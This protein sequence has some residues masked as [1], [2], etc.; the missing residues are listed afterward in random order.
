MNKT[1]L[2]YKAARICEVIGQRAYYRQRVILRKMWME[3]N[4]KV[5]KKKAGGYHLSPADEAEIER[6]WKGF[7]VDKDWFRFYNSIDRGR[8]EAFDAR[9]VPLDIQYCV[10]DEWFNESL[11]AHLMD[12]K[13]MYDLYFGDVCRPKT[14]LHIID[15]VVL[16]DGYN[17]ISIDEAATLCAKQKAVIC[18]PSIETSCGTGIFFW[19]VE[20]G[21]EE[22]KE[23][24]KQCDNYIVQEVVRQHSSIT[25]LHEKSV[26]T[27]RIVTCAFNGTTE[28]LSTVVRFGSGDSVVDNAS[29]GGLFCGVSDDG[30]L[31]RNAYTKTGDVYRDHPLGGDFS[32]CVIPNFDK[33]KEMVLWLSHRF[34]RISKLT[35]WDLAI[36]EDGEPVLIEVCLCYGGADIHQIANGPLF[37]DKTEAVLAAVGSSRKYRR[38]SYRKK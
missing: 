1:N 12:D 21:M 14:V 19:R 6:V 38:R 36:R 5:K 34:H 4:Y 13:N 11:E 30:S 3:A 22:L 37:G 20:D 28:V 23:S 16:D 25:S 17:E 10:V 8:E 15:G 33:C 27:I 7:K 18:K 29:K 32:Q 26:N 24:L 2:R 31:K 35:S 9:Y